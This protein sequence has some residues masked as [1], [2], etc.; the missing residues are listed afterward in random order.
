M[1]YGT[2][3]RRVLTPIMILA[4]VVAAGI[5][6][7]WYQVF[8]PLFDDPRDWAERERAYRSVIREILSGTAAQASDSPALPPWPQPMSVSHRTMV[9]RVDAELAR[10]V[11]LSV[12]YHAMDYPWG[13]LPSHLAASP[14][15][16]IRSLRSVGLDLQQMIHHD[17]TANPGRY[18]THL[19]S[20]RRADRAIDHRRLPNLHA[21]I[22]FFADSRPVLVDSAE[23]RAAFL[24]GDLVFWTPGGGGA[25]PGL[26]GI[27]LDRRNARGYPLVAT[28]T[29]DDGWATDH[30]PINHWPITGHYRVHPDALL[31]RF[32]EQNPTAELLPPGS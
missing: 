31:E 18:P 10:G 26:V 13:D 4:V 16:V 6:A 8:H 32:L 15:L 3:P 27:V 1:Q 7:L 2:Q 25:H 20:A 14:D 29:H 23:K 19:W 28:V 24:P 21:F 22:R 17:R 12:R 30:H 11:R 5:G 9:T